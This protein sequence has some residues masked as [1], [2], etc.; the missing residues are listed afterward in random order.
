MAN[1]RIHWTTEPDDDNEL[2]E[3]RGALYALCDPETD[4]VLYLGKADRQ[5]VRQRIACRSK[6]GVLEYIDVVL[7]IP[8]YVVRVGEISTACRLTAQ[9]LGDIESL[10][11][12]ELAPPAN[13]Q[14]VYERISRP[15]M[16]VSCSGDW[17]A[18]HRNFVDA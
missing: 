2:L 9:L 5:T 8:E 3:C 16:Q 13:I 10:L 12:R 15:G 6:D 18:R 7:D 4:K 14:C 17:L 11:I 1:V